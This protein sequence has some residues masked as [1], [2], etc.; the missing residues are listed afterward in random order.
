MAA[1][2]VVG[3]LAIVLDTKVTKDMKVTQGIL[4]GPSGHVVVDQSRTLAACA[5]PEKNLRDLRDLGDLCVGIGMTMR[6]ATAVR[7]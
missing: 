2:F 6:A 3:A 4:C 5:A 7:R 1:A